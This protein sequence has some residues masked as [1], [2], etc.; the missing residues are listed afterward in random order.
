[1]LGFR[2]P[3][4]PTEF[5]DST[6]SA[7][8]EIERVIARGE[9]PTGKQ[10]CEKWQPHK[11]LFRNAQYGKCGY[12]EHDT[13][14]SYHGDVE[15]Y[16]PKGRIEQIRSERAATNS[17]STTETPRYPVDIVS[18]RG[19][20]WR[21]Y[22]WSNYLYACALCNQVHKRCIFPIDPPQNPRLPDP[23][24]EAAETPLLLNPYEPDFDPAKHF[25]YSEQG[26]ISARAGDTRGWETIRTC[27]LDRIGLCDARR[28]HRDLL[29]FA[30][31]YPIL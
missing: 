6:A 19:Y 24:T 29:S 11:G 30:R 5:A 23:A 27:R 10:F 4:E 16:A 21:A 9:N 31:A 8:Q 3:P 2:R 15:H 14:A 22:D 20:W 28:E 12:C 13:R 18:H 1:M 17:R 26:V 25:C 7:R